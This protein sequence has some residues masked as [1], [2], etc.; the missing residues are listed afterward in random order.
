MRADRHGPA[1]LITVSAM[2]AALVLLFAPGALVGLAV[3]PGSALAA[4]LL[5]G[6]VRGFRAAILTILFAAVFL[7]DAMFRVRDYTDKGVDFQVALKIGIWALLV[8]VSLV[9]WR[10]WLLSLFLPT[11]MLWLMLLGWLVFTSTLSPIPVYSAVAALSICAYI[12]FSAYLFANFDRVEVLAVIVLAIAAFCAVSIV[13]Y[14]TIPELGRFIYWLNGELFVSAR[15]AGIAGSANNMGRIAAFGLL[16]IIL[17][18]PDFQRFH[19]WFV[20]VCAPLMLIC[21]YLTNSRSSM[22][23]VLM[24]WAAV[25]L[26]NWRRLYLLVFAVSLALLGAVIALPGGDE[27]LML[28][29][30]N[31][32]IDEVTSVT[33]RSD[34]WSAVPKLIEGRSWTGFGYASSLVV[35]PQYEGEVGFL[36]SHAHNLILQLLLTTGWIGVGLFCLSTLMTGLRAAYLGDRA[37]LMLLAFVILNGIT[38]SSAFTTLANVCSLAF[39]IAV[40]LPPEPQDYENDSTYQRGFS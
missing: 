9:H 25:L 40:T 15:M 38:E 36:A 19:R 27:V 3:L 33:G 13:V 7:L 39:A 29:A 14:F 24:L 31:G 35:L 12:L 32:N 23:M 26:L 1:I 2:G 4:M 21:L 11:N 8:M 37:V 17:Y 28:L 22:A 30:R 16:L 10:S 5:W 20:P 18:G 6:A 34:I